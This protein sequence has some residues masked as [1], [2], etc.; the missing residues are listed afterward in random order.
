MRP[1]RPL[2][3][4]SVGWD[5]PAPADGDVLLDPTGAA[6]RVLSVACGPGAGQWRI[7]AVR[8]S[9]FSWSVPFDGDARP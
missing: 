6:V 2:T 8:C 1:D 9:S 5:G 4:R 7:E 3:L